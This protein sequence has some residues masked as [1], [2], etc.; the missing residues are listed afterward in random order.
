MDTARPWWA[1]GRSAL[2]AAC[3]ASVKGLQTSTE[4]CQKSGSAATA[5]SR[6]LASLQS[7]QQS[8]QGPRSREWTPPGRGGPVGGVPL[9]QPA[10]PL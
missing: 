7:C 8:L 6:P 3:P 1:R 9:V 5:L 2:G 4:A 10:L